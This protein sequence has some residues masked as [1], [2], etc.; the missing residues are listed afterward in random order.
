MLLLVGTYHY[1]TEESRGLLWGFLLEVVQPPAREDGYPKYLE[2][3]QLL[4]R[5]REVT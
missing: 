4:L 3:V 5:Q 2:V 1:D